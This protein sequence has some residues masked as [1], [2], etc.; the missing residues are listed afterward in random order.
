MSIKA[1]RS[2]ASAIA[3]RSS[4]LSNGGLSRLTIRLVLTLP[5]GS[6]QIASGRCFC[7]SRVSGIVSV[8][9]KVSSYLPATKARIA[10]ERFCD[11]RVFDAVEIGQPRLPVIRVLRHLDV[12]VGLELDEFE[13]AGA[14]RML[15]HLRRRDVA[16]IDRRHAGGEQRE[17]GGLR[18]LQDECR[19][20][21]RRWSTISAR[22]SYQA[23]RGLTRS[24]SA[25]LA[26]HQVP[27]AFDVGGGERLA[28]MPFHAL[29]AAGKSAACRPRPTPSRWR[30]RARSSARLFC[31]TCWSNM[32]E[33]VHHRHHRP[34]GDDRRLLVDRHAGRAVDDVLPKDAALFLG[35]GWCAATTTTLSNP[36]ATVEC[37][38]CSLHSVP[39]HLA[40]ARH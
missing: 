23:L 2:S 7:R 30:A 28:V 36:P 33:V 5:G 22:L 34:L 31:A 17:K 27:G 12:L 3:R 11:D 14:D 9:A 13:R 8:P 26:L 10:V 24:F 35:E 39:S 32:H 15:A 37:A 29:G 19:P 20:R 16:G 25:R 4:G 18:P 40:R 21:N 38:Q 1:W 6:S